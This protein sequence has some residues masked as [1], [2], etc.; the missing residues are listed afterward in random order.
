M[1]AAPVPTHRI[2]ARPAARPR[3]TPPQQAGAARNAV[4]VH[5]GTIEIQGPPAP[6]VAEATP[7]PP[8][9]QPAAPLR[10]AF[11]EFVALR[12]YTPWRW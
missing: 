3:P 5:I 10:G 12:T 6:A 8:P 11:D 9:Q 7:P 1:R 4:E 2:A